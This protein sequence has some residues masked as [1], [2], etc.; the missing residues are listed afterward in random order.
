MLTSGDLGSKHDAASKQASISVA[1]CTY[2]GERYLREQLESIAKQTLLPSELIVCDDQSADA[3]AKIISDFAQSAPFPVKFIRNPQNLGSTKNFE[4]AISLCNGEFIALCDQDDIWQPEKLAHQS[5]KLMR[6]R[7][8]GGV[9][10]DAE[11]VD[12]RSQETGQRLWLE[13]YFT[14][15]K[16]VKFRAGEETAVMLQGN[17][18]TGATLMIRANLRA[19]FLPIPESAVHDCWIAWM[20]VLCSKLDFIEAALVHYRVHNLQQIGTGNLGISE[21]LPLWKRLKRARVDD[22]AKHL[23]AARELEALEQ[24]LLKIDDPGVRAVLQS[25]RDKIGFLKERASPRR[26]SISRLYFI[27][28][29]F[30]NYNRYDR[31]WKCWARDIASSLV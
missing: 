13:F 6:E 28:K 19:L 20:T 3:T 7:E 15:R 2:N 22:A 24:R 21:R 18:V 16:Q 23:R 14:T 9:F 27:L 25:L 11:I 5:E 10:S 1:M 29:N 31:D 30:Y 4:K 12:D 17:V 8:L 26:S